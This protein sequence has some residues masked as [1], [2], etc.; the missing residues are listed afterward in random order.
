MEAAIAGVEVHA[1]AIEQMILGQHLE[2]PAW[3]PELKFFGY[4]FLA[5]CSLF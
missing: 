4:F 3:M 2:R 1:M 5:P